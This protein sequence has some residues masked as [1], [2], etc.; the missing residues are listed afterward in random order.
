MGND[1]DADWLHLSDGETVVWQSRPH[2][3][4]MGWRLP[5]GLGLVLLGMFFLALSATNSNQ[6][7]TATGLVLSTVGLG[8]L[9]VGYVFW[10][11]TRYVLTSGELYQKHGVVSRDVTQFRLE[12]IQN[13]SLQQGY[14]GR[15]LGYGDLTVYTAGSADPELTFRFTPRPERAAAHLN[16]QL[17]GVS[18]RNS[19]K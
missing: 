17:E 6:L 13:T 14:L 7:V 10:T 2:P 5:L 4:A 19:P 12:R 16:D 1:F 11:N 18:R 8:V 9:L 3:I 15:L